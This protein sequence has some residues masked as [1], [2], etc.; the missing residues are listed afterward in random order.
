MLFFVSSCYFCMQ[1]ASD[2]TAH[3]GLLGCWNYCIDIWS[4]G[5]KRSRSI[6]LWFTSLLFWIWL[7]VSVK[8]SPL[9]LKSV[10]I[11]LLDGDW[12]SHSCSLGQCCLYGE[13]KSSITNSLYSSKRSRL[14]IMFTQLLINY[15]CGSIWISLNTTV[16]WHA[17]WNHSHTHTHTHT[18]LVH[19]MNTISRL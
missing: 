4:E 9:F 6:T 1:F 10:V 17:V 16:L 3:G 13:P 12:L 11:N 5:L 19:K 2:G 7:S 8:K 15:N 18:K 14:K